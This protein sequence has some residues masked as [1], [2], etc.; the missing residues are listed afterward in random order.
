V[1]NREA[2]TLFD[3]AKRL[4]ADKQ[5]EE[6]LTRLD[7]LNEVFPR[8]R[9]ILYPR[10]L[11]LAKLGRFEQAKKVAHQLKALHGDPRAARLLDKL[12]RREQDNAAHQ[13][14]DM[15]QAIEELM[16]TELTPSAAGPAA[17]LQNGLGFAAP[18]WLLWAAAIGLAALLGAAAVLFALRW[19]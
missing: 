8:T 1:N 3:E 18:D 5:F 11:C 17:R 9:N 10:A 6:A 13:P 15:T 2:L 14:V 16:A 4:F 7:Q 19:L 12:H